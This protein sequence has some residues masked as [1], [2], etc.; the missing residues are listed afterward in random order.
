MSAKVPGSD[1][2]LGNGATGAF[3]NTVRLDGTPTR[4]FRIYKSTRAAA[5][6]AV[7]ARKSPR[8]ITQTQAQQAFDKFY[9]RTRTIKRGPRKGQPRFASPRGR[10]AART[11]DLTHRSNN[12]DKLISD[13]RYLH[14]PH[15]YEFQGV[16]TGNK[17][18][19][20]MSPAQRAALKRGQDAIKAKNIAKA[21]A[22]RAALGQAGGYWW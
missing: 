15:A 19:K 17:V 9:K 4:V 20:P 18:R 10:K 6:E 12:P 1:R 16:D 21:A 13:A 5:M 8:Q 22:K 11:Y 14:N 2:L 7:A 3:F